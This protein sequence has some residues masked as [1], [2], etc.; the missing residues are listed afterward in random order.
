MET[1]LLS[2]P[3][4]LV[5]GALALFF[6]LMSW[7]KKNTNSARQRRQRNFKQNYREKR[8]ERE[9]EKED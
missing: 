8:K 1:S 5:G 2:N 9:K 4:V 6:V 7:N 3:Y